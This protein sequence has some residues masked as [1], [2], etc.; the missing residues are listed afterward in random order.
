MFFPAIIILDISI[1][2]LATAKI[3]LREIIETS[4]SAK[5]NLHEN[6]AKFLSAKINPAGNWS[7]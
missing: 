5:V 1:T 4:P 3:S 6:V 7:P 2:Y